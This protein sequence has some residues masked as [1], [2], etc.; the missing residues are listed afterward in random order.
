MS[1]A[2]GGSSSEEFL[3]TCESG[4]DTFVKCPNCGLAANVEAIVTRVPE[5]VDATGIPAAHVEDTPDTPT[6][7]SLVEVSNSRT[8]LRR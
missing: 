4:E 6:I 5:E 1:G 3:A 8:E 2:L 7:A